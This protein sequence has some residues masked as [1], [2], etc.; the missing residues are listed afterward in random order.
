MMEEYGM[1]TKNHQ[2]QLERCKEEIQRLRKAAMQSQKEISILHREHEAEKQK[3]I[4]N[5]KQKAAEF[6]E[7]VRRRFEEMQNS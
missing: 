7:G 1:T 4:D 3:L 5:F 2:E 6:K